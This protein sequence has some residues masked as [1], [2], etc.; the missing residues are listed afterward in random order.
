MR[1]LVWR[2]DGD[3]GGR[4]WGG[5]VGSVVLVKKQPIRPSVL[6]FK[7]GICEKIFHCKEY[8]YVIEKKKYM[9]FHFKLFVLNIC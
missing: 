9:F 3:G 2:L 7:K 5:G 4:G 8:S 1:F 6:S